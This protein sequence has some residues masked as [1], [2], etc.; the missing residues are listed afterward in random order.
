MWDDD[1]CLR[2]FRLSKSFYK[3]D[4]VALSD[5][6]DEEFNPKT[7][8]QLTMQWAEA[9]GN[10]QRSENGEELAWDDRITIS[11]ARRGGYRMSRKY[12]FMTVTEFLNDF[13]V[14]VKTIKTIKV[15]SR[16]NEEGTKKID[17][18]VFKAMPGD[19]YRFRIYETFVEVYDEQ[20][21]NILTPAERLRKRE[22]QDVMEQLAKD[23]VADHP[24][25][26]RA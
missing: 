21:N 9:D 11:S 14:E 25:V 20:E 12:G 6:M 3:R 17:G 24:L 5:G 16:W 4:L 22:P 2:C 26:I 1:S 19:E 15:V 23:T 7:A 18:I 8:E 10:L 13:E